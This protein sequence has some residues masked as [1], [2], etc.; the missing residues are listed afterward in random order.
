[1]MM[2][3]NRRWRCVSDELRPILMLLKFGSFSF[4]RFWSTV[5]TDPLDLC[6]QNPRFMFC[7][8][9]F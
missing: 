9:R 3:E 6:T 1:M 8:V 4:S 2:T 5:T 7:I